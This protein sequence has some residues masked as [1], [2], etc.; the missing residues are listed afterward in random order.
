GG[1]ALA[2]WTGDRHTVFG[3][4]QLVRCGGHFEGYQV[5]HWPHGCAGRGVLF[6]GDQPQV[7]MDRRW[8]TFMYSYPNFIPFDAATV[9]SI[10][11]TLEPLPFDR[12]YGA[13]GRHVLQ[14]AK[15]TISRSRRRYLTAIGAGETPEADPSGQR[16]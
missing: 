6:A 3:D 4:L 13:F 15:D 7:C 11:R 12:L 5:L 8:V 9:D 2:F 14:N 16:P 10:T 1:E